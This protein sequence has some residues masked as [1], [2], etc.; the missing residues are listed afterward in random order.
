MLGRTERRLLDRV[1]TAEESGQWAGDH[2]RG[3]EFLDA[4]AANFVPGEP[5]HEAIADAPWLIADSTFETCFSADRAESS[6]LS[7][8]PSSSEACSRPALIC[9][10]PGCAATG[11]M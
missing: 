10:W 8:Q 3:R 11:L 5:L 1:I 2:E 4:L 7:D 9:C 6:T